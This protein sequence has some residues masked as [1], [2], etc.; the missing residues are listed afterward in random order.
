MYGKC[1]PKEF[2]FFVIL[3]RKIWFQR[4]S[5]V[6]GGVFTGPNELIQEAYASIDDFR[7]VNAKAIK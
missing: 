6:H 4:N 2:E 5:V 7:K 3:A 1:S